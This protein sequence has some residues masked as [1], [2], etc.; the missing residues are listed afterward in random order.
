MTSGK[1]YGDFSPT[2]GGEK[3]HHHCCA[4]WRQ[5]ADLNWGQSESVE[6]ALRGGVPD[7][8]TWPL[9]DQYHSW[10]SIVGSQ[11]D[12]LFFYLFIFLHCTLLHGDICMLH[13]AIYVL[14]YY[15]IY[16]CHIIVFYSFF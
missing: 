8:I 2:S 12:F 10:G 14:I 5:G 1:L 6:G 7:S 4:W 16:Y 11:S 13:D 9:N 3:A 15:Y